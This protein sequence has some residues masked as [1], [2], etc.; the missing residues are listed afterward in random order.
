MKSQILFLIEII[1]TEFWGM[2]LRRGKAGEWGF[3]ILQNQVSHILKKFINL[4]HIL[5]TF[6][7]QI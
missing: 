2:P 5:I 1:L 4:I 6:H 3:M 7:Q